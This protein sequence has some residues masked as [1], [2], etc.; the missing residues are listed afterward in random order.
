M[1]SKRVEEELDLE[2]INSETSIVPQMPEEVEEQLPVRR[3]R[4]NKEVV[5]NT[6]R[7]SKLFKK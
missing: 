4:S 6:G 1:A 2:S 5:S 3:G 7:T